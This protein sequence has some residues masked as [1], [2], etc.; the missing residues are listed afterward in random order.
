MD[1]LDII[2]KKLY[3][4]A[5]QYLKK[6]QNNNIS[7]LSNLI[8]IQVICVILIGLYMMQLLFKT[9]QDDF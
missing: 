1:F 9:I 4:D 6:N 3:D 5:K 8:I 7:Q 2:G